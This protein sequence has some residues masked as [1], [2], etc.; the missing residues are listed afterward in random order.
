MKRPMLSFT[1][2]IVFA[3]VSY[4]QGTWHGWTSNNEQDCMSNSS[5]CW[6]PWATGSASCDA[7]NLGMDGFRIVGGSTRILSQCPYGGLGTAQISNN[8]PYSFE[9][10]WYDEDTDEAGNLAYQYHAFSDCTYPTSQSGDY[11]ANNNDSYEDYRS[12]FG[13]NLS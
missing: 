8:L 13:C 5:A 12:Y 11:A 6:T 3:G 10:T 9:L 1:L 7:P 2:L 4:G